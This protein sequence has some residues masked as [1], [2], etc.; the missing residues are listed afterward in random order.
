MFD[1]TRIPERIEAPAAMAL[2]RH[3]L[4]QA[5]E[6]ELVA[7]TGNAYAYVAL[8]GYDEGESALAQAPASGDVLYLLAAAGQTLERDAPLA[9][10][11]DG[12]VRLG[13]P[14]TDSILAYASEAVAGTTAGQR[15][16][17]NWK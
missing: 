12:T 16:A 9:S 11:G 2:E 17:A 6:G 15:I 10:N 14:A 7:H 13:D 1:P 8:N 4:T 3:T 5:S